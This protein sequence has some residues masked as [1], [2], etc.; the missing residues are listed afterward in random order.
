MGHK[1]LGIIVFFILLLVL[2]NEIKNISYFIYKY[3]FIKDLSKIDQS[4]CDDLYTEAETARFQIAKNMY[5][6]LL[7]NDI[8]NS[9]TYMVLIMIFSIFL[10]VYVCYKYIKYLN[11]ENYLF[12]SIISALIIIHFVI[13]L[14]L[15]IVFRYVPYDERG[16]MN[17]FLGGNEIANADAFHSSIFP[18]LYGMMLIYY[19]YNMWKD[20]DN[21]DFQ[22]VVSYWL[23]YFYYAL[24]LFFMLNMINIVESFKTNNASYDIEPLDKNQTADI[25]YN[26]ENEFYNKYFD[27]KEIPRGIFINPKI[28]SSKNDN[29]AYGINKLYMNNIEKIAFILFIFLLFAI[30]L[31]MLWRFTG[32]VNIDNKKMITMIYMLLPIVFLFLLLTII[33][34]FMKFNTMFNKDVLY[35]IN[36]VY[37]HDLNDLNNVVT[38]YISLY[39]NYT[40][41]QK[42][43]NFVYN[44]VVFNVLMSYF[45]G[46]M[47]MFKNDAGT[48]KIV[49]TNIYRN[50]DYFKNNNIK[51]ARI[52]INDINREDNFKT[53]Y[54]ERINNILSGILN[55]DKQILSNLRV[56]TINDFMSELFDYNLLNIYNDITV[57]DSNYSKYFKYDAIDS[58]KKVYVFTEARKSTIKDNI[59]RNIYKMFEICEMDNFNNSV[60]KQNSEL[61]KYYEDSKN[62]PE[63]LKYINMCLS[64]SDSSK[65]QS[66]IYKFMIKY[67]FPYS[68][69]SEYTRLKDKYKKLYNQVGN[70]CQIGDNI[71]LETLL[72]NVIDNFITQMECFYMD[73]EDIK[74]NLNIYTNP[75]STVIVKAEAVKNIQSTFNNS[76]SRILKTITDSVY[77]NLLEHKS[78][79]NTT[80]PDCLNL[81]EIN[82]TYT[83]IIDNIKIPLESNSNYLKNVIENIFY[84]LNDAQC[85]VV[86]YDFDT[87]G[88]ASKD[89][90]NVNVTNYT[91]APSTDML[92]KLEIMNVYKKESNEDT[93]HRNSSIMNSNPDKNNHINNDIIYDKAHAVISQEFLTIYIINMFLICVVYLLLIYT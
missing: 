91:N 42:Q 40:S 48:S 22:K 37:K 19:A 31:I 63:I 55:S 47:D 2:I 58:T 3:M 54:D 12:A 67:P 72:D 88:Y 7:P 81:K 9:K 11:D 5:D 39:N 80:S 17:Y 29:Y 41:L 83:H 34:N 15:N 6:L 64:P 86:L 13:I 30:I 84:K 24:A 36:S 8:Y 46:H 56:E 79:N 20:Y 32:S 75:S 52:E 45:E 92:A 27:L 87:T 50:I 65:K 33:N 78:I 18:T 73:Y 16:Y 49:D 89:I 35:G 51:F 59:K 68:D 77:K 26:T 69:D 4:K 62:K 76:V 25:S 1:F 66:Y 21:F 90:V 38:P 10:Y 71:N 93:L 82:Y 14:I 61:E 28:F 43:T 44:Y 57:S 70:S 85:R 74:T 23:Y 60:E 53:Y